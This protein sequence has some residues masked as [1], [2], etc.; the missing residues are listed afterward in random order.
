MAEASIEFQYFEHLVEYS[1]AVCRECKHGVLPNHIES[2]LQRVHRIKHSQAHSITE[3]VH[4]WP[5][6][7]AYASELQ[8]YAAWN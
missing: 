4:S 2:H 6:L 3:R 5:G 1:I 7:V 8:A